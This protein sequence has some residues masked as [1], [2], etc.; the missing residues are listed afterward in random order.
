[1]L[2]LPSR[3][4]TNYERGVTVPGVILLEFLELTGVEPP[5][6]L[7]GAGEKYRM[8]TPRARRKQYSELFV[9]LYGG[10]SDPGGNPVSAGWRHPT[11]VDVAASARRRA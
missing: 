8:A 2:R 10:E 7:R 3:T 11:A 1:M 5:W 4:W 6:L 9:F